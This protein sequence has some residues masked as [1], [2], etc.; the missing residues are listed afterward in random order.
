[1]IY[2]HKRPMGDGV[3]KRMEP[4]RSWFMVMME[5]LCFVVGFCDLLWCVICSVR[6]QRVN[7]GNPGASSHWT[8]NKSV[9]VL[10]RNK[11]LVKYTLI[12]HGRRT[13]PKAATNRF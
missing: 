4:S 8:I 9:S 1:M 5:S 12:H 10:I 3:R 13:Y 7:Q 6:R 11:K 2:Y